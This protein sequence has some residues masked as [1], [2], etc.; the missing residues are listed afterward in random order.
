M[1]LK[2]ITASICLLAGG[3]LLAAPAAKTQTGPMRAQLRAVESTVAQLQLAQRNQHN[4]TNY[5]QSSW[6]KRINV[7]GQINVDGILSDTG[8]GST[9]TTAGTRETNSDITMTNASL[10]IDTKP[11][12]WL[13]T[14]ISLLFDDSSLLSSN[15]F[16]KGF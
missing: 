6:H 7:G 3:T 12:D 13:T 14:H 16:V 15:N 5:H 11:I 10:F 1:K 2:V 4:V 9:G 8:F